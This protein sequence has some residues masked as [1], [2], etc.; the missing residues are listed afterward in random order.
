[1]S[2]AGRGDASE[3]TVSVVI[4][5]RDEETDIAG[6][7]RAVAAQTWGPQRLE[8][9]VVDGGSVDH[10]VHVVRGEAEALDFGRFE[11]LDNAAQ[12]IAPG[13]NLGLA[14]ARGDVLVRVDARSRIEPD[15]VALAVALLRDRPGVGVVGGPQTALPRDGG[16]L[17]TGIARALRNQWTTGMARY[18]RSRVAG[19]ADTVWMGAFRTRE[20]RELG[21]WDD[22]LELNEDYDLNRR[23][24]TA[25]QLVW[26]DPALAAGYLPRRDLRSLARQYYRFGQ[27][28]GGWWSRGWAP[29]PRQILLLGMPP[30]AGLATLLMGR[31]FGWLAASG[32]VAAAVLTVEGLG[33]SGPP[34]VLSARAVSVAATAVTCSAWW[35]GAVKEL[36]SVRLRPVRRGPVRRG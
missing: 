31:R 3:P 34:G 6:C 10:T 11:V 33:S 32:S 9:I 30:V 26:F 21:G 29:A 14:H 2:D 12:R 15:H 28:K 24:R 35:F 17:A 16:A 8:V 36:T 4:P 18:R 1:M 5:V 19:P 7:L 27:A 20:L 23:Y 22:T 25:G 13:L